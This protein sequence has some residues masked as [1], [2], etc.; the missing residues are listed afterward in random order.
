MQRPDPLIMV[1]A[2]PSW[3]GRKLVLETRASNGTKEKNRK[4]RSAAGQ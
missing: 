1:T 2:S 3:D 4:A